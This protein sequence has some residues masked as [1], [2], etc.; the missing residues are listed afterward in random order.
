MLIAALTEEIVVAHVSLPVIAQIVLALGTSLTMEFLVMDLEMDSVMMKPTILT[1]TT[2]AL[3]AAYL[4]LIQTP[5]RNAYVMV[6]PSLY[7]ISLFFSLT[8]STT[9]YFPKTLRIL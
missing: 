3:T 6:S 2:M 7:K 5:A 1:A 9:D 8:F 4:Q